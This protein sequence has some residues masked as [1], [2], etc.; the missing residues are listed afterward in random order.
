LLGEI[1]QAHLGVRTTIG[2]GRC[3]INNIKKI[4]DPVAASCGGDAERPS[5][6][7][8]DLSMLCLEILQAK[9]DAN[10]GSSSILRRCRTC[11]KPL[12]ASYTCKLW[13]LLK[14]KLYIALRTSMIAPL[15]PVAPG[16]SER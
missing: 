12:S 15:G 1:V 3:E 13:F 5:E 10:V 9:D 7:S 4:R 16:R 8:P 2:V 6:V 11:A 14:P